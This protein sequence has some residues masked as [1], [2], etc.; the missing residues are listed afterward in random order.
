MI[1]DSKNEQVSSFLIEWRTITPLAEEDFRTVRLTFQRAFVQ[2]VINPAIV[3][4]SGELALF[5]H[6]FLARV[7]S[8]V[9]SFDCGSEMIL[10]DIYWVSVGRLK[11]DMFLTAVERK[12]KR[13]C[14]GTRESKV[15]LVTWPKFLLPVEWRVYLK[16][17]YGNSHNP[18]FAENDSPDKKQGINTGQEDASLDVSAFGEHLFPVQGQWR[19]DLE[20]ATEIFL[21]LGD[22]SIKSWLA[23]VGSP[24]DV[25]EKLANRQAAVTSNEPL[26]DSS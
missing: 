22:E 16:A 20:W 24:P 2:E 6:K 11:D 5:Y 15:C 21:V 23:K 25:Y 10:K 18:Y 7:P 4:H 9:H 14:I 12:E 8:G 17:Y 19:N 1:I 13:H 3:A 26:S